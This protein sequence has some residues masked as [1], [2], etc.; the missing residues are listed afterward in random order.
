M[1]STDCGACAQGKGSRFRMTGGGESL[2]NQYLYRAFGEQTD[3][4]MAR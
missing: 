4:E 2:V 3:V 1:I